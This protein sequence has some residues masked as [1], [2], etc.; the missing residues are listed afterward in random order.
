MHPPS[1]PGV[2]G[3]VTPCC[4][5][6]CRLSEDLCSFQKSSSY[7]P[8]HN[9]K[10]GD[11]N[12]AASVRRKDHEFDSVS[13]AHNVLPTHV[14]LQLASGSS[15][16]ATHLSSPS[17]IAQ[18]CSSVTPHRVLIGC[19]LTTAGPMTSVLFCKAEHVEWC[20]PGGGGGGGGGGG[21]KLPWIR[22][23]EA[24]SIL[25]SCSTGPLA[26][27][28]RPMESSEAFVRHSSPYLT[29]RVVASLRVLK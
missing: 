9:Q 7:G 22:A 12:T 8:P 13:V 21:T 11:H 16:K 20:F 29:A 26:H 28:C 4:R 25:T 19:V 2:V 5:K 6:Y 1:A 27:P 24:R 14:P 15:V 17:H 23:P 18:H 10:R 3:A